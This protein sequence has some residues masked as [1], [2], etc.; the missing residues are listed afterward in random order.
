MAENSSKNNLG[1][2]TT[3]TFEVLFKRLQTS[4]EGLSS[5]EAAKRQSQYGLNKLKEEKEVWF[6]ILMRQFTLP[7]IYLL[8][9]AAIIALFLGNTLE[10]LLIIFFIV[11]NSFL[12]FYQEYKAQQTANLLK[13][14]LVA[15]SK[16]FRDNHLTMID[17]EML[18]P[19]DVIILEPGD[20][21]PADVRF[22]Q[23][24][25][26]V[27]DESELT[28]ESVPVKK[29]AEP[30]KEPAHELFNAFN[31][32]S[33]GTVVVQGKAVAVV[34]ATGQE[35]YQGVVATLTSRLVRESIFS[36]EIAQFSHFILILVTVTLVLVF[37]MNLIIKG[38]QAHI[39]DLLLFSIALAVTITPEALPIVITFCLSRGALRLARNK[40]IVKRLSAIEDL[41]S[42]DILC[43][44]KT[45]TLTENKLAVA[46]IYAEDQQKVLLY[47]ILASSMFEKPS[48]LVN[49]IDKAFWEKLE[50][51]QQQKRALYKRVYEIPFD[52]LR[53]PFFFFILSPGNNFL[54][55]NIYTSINNR[56]SNTPY[57]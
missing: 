43:S 2:Y 20:T 56:I 16:T 7:F 21:I 13:K 39:F 22:I 15:Q 5:Q 9:A 8:G 26:L 45:G 11:V 41:G 57:D 55:I 36:K 30:L 19:G 52:P 40:V 28:G 50:P 23:E 27:V 29:V 3:E 35:S 46:Q 51:S 1:L 33:A 4:A 48:Q 42:I 53:L 24:H 18:V 31:I 44:D 49:P 6:S 38:A 54:F 47:G 17:N 14:Y 12:G 10:A 32:G 37:L 34:L 25:N